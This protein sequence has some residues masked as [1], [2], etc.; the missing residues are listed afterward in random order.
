[1]TALLPP[2]ED[3]EADDYSIAD[4]AAAAS[5]STWVS[6]AVNLGLTATQIFAGVLTKSQGLVA[7]GLHSLSDLIA[8]FV[9]LLA[10]HHSRKEA[11]KDH[12]YGHHRYETAASLVLGLLLLA[13]GL[14]MLWTAVIKL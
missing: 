13:V 12:P 2:T 9:V 11:D 6:V 14:G 8:D 1:M 5:R 4:R 3:S 10:N 7:D